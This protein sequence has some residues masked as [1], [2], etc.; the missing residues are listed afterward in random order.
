MNE[1]RADTFSKA[2]LRNGF[3]G[4][5][6]NGRDYVGG[7]YLIRGIGYV[8]EVDDGQVRR[9][10]GSHKPSEF[11]RAGGAQMSASRSVQHWELR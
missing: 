10:I 4:L 5:L 8:L 6:F 9:V 1:T 7:V 3:K 11:R 2:D